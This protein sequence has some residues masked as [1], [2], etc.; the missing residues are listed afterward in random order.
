MTDRRVPYGDELTVA[1][2]SWQAGGSAP[3]LVRLHLGRGEPEPAAVVA[4]LA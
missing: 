1:A 3:P 2:R 4:R